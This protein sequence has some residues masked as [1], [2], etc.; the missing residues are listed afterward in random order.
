MENI[1]D[2]NTQLSNLTTNLSEKTQEFRYDITNILDRV[3]ELEIKT[4]QSN[5]EI[6]ENQRKIE[7]IVLNLRDKMNEFE[8]LSLIKH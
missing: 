5:V 7:L 4:F 6:L 2:L 3:Q 1:Q 8:K